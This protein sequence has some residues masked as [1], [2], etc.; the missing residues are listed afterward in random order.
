MSSDLVLYRFFDADGGLL[1]VGIAARFW[2]RFSAHRRTSEFFPE[3]ATVTMQRGF[4]SRD[5]LLAAEAAAI[6]A[7]KPQF[8]VV[9]NRPKP[10]PKPQRGWVESDNARWR[11]IRDLE[12]RNPCGKPHYCGDSVHIPSGVGGPCHER[13]LLDMEKL[14]PR[15]RRDQAVGGHG[16][17][18][19]PA[20]AEVERITERLRRD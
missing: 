18:E 6:R 1:Y 9:H 20:G 19:C 8:N 10:K 14:V 15:I 17:W 4:A 16:C 12:I 2:T 3:A 5:D 11:R 13:D 7:E